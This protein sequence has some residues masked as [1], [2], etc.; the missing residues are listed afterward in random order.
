MI[1]LWNPLIQFIHLAHVNQ[2]GVNQI[3]FKFP[4][5]Y[6]ASILYGWVSYGF[7]SGLFELAVIIFDETGEWHLVNDTPITDD[8]VGY[9]SSQEVYDLLLQIKDLPPNQLL[10][11]G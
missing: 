3:L 10:L 6:G 1:E 11:E 5:G 2:L 4:N 8:V 9:L 7:E